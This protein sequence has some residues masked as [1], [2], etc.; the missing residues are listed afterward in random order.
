MLPCP[1]KNK[2]RLK[3]GKSG[4]NMSMLVFAS[5]EIR[6]LVQMEAIVHTKTLHSNCDSY[7]HPV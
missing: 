3:S 5:F 2:L 7:R 6:L 4:E 1:E